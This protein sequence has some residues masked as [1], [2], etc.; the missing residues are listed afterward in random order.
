MLITQVLEAKEAS[1]QWIQQMKIIEIVLMN[2]PHLRLKLLEIDLNRNSLNLKSKMH[3]LLKSKLQQRRAKIKR[4]DLQ[5]IIA[6]VKK[7]NWI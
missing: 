7:R 4:L 6:R 2:L 5:E 1:I 3:N